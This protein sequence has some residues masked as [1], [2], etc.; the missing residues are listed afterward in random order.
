M[1]GPEILVSP[2]QVLVFFTP[3]PGVFN[4]PC[5]PS[6]TTDSKGQ[7]QFLQQWLP[8]A[9]TWGPRAQ[10]SMHLEVHSSMQSQLLFYLFISR[11]HKESSDLIK[12]K[13]FI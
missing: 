7:N 9:V 1:H 2:L 4:P 3:P 6:P 12:D 8:L 10:S 11:F 5:P 13:T